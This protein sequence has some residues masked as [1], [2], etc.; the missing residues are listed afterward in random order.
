MRWPDVYGFAPAPP[1]RYTSC[2]G[3]V[4]TVVALLSAL[5][6]LVYFSYQLAHAEYDVS[7]SLRDS[8]Q[9]SVL[10][11]SSTPEIPQV[12]TVRK[13][14]QVKFSGVHGNK[15][16]RCFVCLQMGLSF[17][18]RDGS[19]L[20]QPGVVEVLFRQRYAE[21][22]YMATGVELRDVVIPAEK[23]YIMDRPEHKQTT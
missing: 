6:G 19:V 20:Q 12:R 18:L 9:N 1:R 17:R 10:S 5:W 8:E 11:P 14:P 13:P 2:C 4:F 23:C 16:G 7:V 3:F 15:S 22:G 21:D